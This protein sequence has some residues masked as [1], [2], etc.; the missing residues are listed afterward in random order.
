MIIHGGR[1]I[2]PSQNLD[3]VCDIEIEEG[4]IKRLGHF[5]SFQNTIDASGLIVAPGL[6]DVHVHF[7]DPG[8]TEKEDL[9]TGALAAARGGFTSVICMGNTIP[10]M[11]SPELVYEFYKKAKKEKIHLYTVA[12][13]TKEMRG[14]VLTDLE[15]L[16]KAGVVGISDD[17]F[18]V[19]EEELLLEGM[20]QCKKLDLPLSLHEEDPRFIGVPGI[21]DGEISKEM[22]YRG[23]SA[24]GE[25]LYISRDVIFSR[26]TGCKVDI[27]HISSGYGVKL[28][29][30]ARAFGGNVVAEITPHHFTLTEDDVKTY[31]TLAKMNPPLRTKKDRELL[32]QGIKNGTITIIASDHAPHTEEEKNREYHKAPSG[33]TGLETALALGLRELVEKEIID[34]PQLISLMSTNPAKF[35]NLPGGTL[36]EG[37]SA[38]LVIFDPKKTWTYDKVFSRSK[39]SPFLGENLPGKIYYTICQGDIVYR[40]K[41]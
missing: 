7:R 36:K 13:L 22:G 32:L 41:M 5:K 31:G 29:E 15:A 23:A 38:D 1:V 20:Y 40:D 4:K 17:G 28:V 19:T 24:Y 27:Q 18:P 11:D 6:V 37:S 9:H 2:D 3:E 34:L 21:N 30:L 26:L 12:N 33:I 39:N 14:K 8:Q 35:Y 16:K 25:D 10:P